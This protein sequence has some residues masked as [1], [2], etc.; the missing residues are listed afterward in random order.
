MSGTVPSG[1]RVRAR[2]I[3][4]IALGVGVTL[5]LAGIVGLD[6]A[7]AEAQPYAVAS[8]SSTMQTATPQPPET[9]TPVE[10]HEAPSAGALLQQYLDERYGPGGAGTSWHANIRRVGMRFGTAVV[11]TDLADG[12][13]TGQKAAAISEAVLGFGATSWGRRLSGLA[14]EV[15]GQGGQLLAQDH[16]L[17]TPGP[18]LPTTPSPVLMADP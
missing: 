6:L 17:L 11:Q 2:A 15:Y 18:I 9:P 3:V 5:A 12:P 16:A 13:E 1:V 4:S 7:D 8:E 14:V 10:V